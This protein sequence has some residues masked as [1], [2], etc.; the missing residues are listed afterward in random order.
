MKREKTREES[1]EWLEYRREMQQDKMIKK[2]HL[3]MYV[4]KLIESIFIII[5]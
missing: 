1:N 5:T 2:S 3:R 4:Y